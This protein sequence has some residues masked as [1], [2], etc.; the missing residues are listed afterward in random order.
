MYG[1]GEGQFI[2]YWD[3]KVY[4][5]E[6][7]SFPGVLDNKQ[8]SRVKVYTSKKRAENA[9]N[10]LNEKFVYVTNAEIEILD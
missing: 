3:G 2:G 10:K 5:A 6:D 4:F 7:T 8:D 1:V 9:V